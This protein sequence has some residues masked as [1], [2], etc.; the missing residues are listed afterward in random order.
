MCIITQSGWTNLGS[1]TLLIH[2]PRLGMDCQFFRTSYTSTELRATVLA[3]E[4]FILKDRA[5]GIGPEPLQAGAFPTHEQPRSGHHGL[6][7]SSRC[8]WQ[9][10]SPPMWSLLALVHLSAVC[11][12][13]TKTS[14]PWKQRWHLAHSRLSIMIVNKM[15]ASLWS[16][17]ETNLQK[18]FHVNYW[19]EPFSFMDWN[20]FPPLFKILMK[21][22]FVYMLKRT[23]NF[24]YF[25]K[26]F[27]FC[28]SFP[29]RKRKKE[30]V[31]FMHVHTRTHTHTRM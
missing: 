16:L 6:G 1:M 23:P 3:Q 9:Q 12:H 4:D 18:D 25:L 29:L 20:P 13:L 28:F 27:T 22:T 14:H 11:P 15:L 8:S 5:L 31:L 2:H 19:W 10:P 7:P 30:C 26:L 21:S 17:C 24:Q